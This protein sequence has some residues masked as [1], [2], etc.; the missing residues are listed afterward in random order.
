MRSI[1]TGISC[2]L[3]DAM[4]NV[5]GRKIANLRL[6]LVTYRANLTRRSEET[7]MKAL[8]ADVGEILALAD[9]GR[10]VLETY[11]EGKWPETSR[12]FKAKLSAV[13]LGR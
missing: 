2:R 8:L 12:F 7:L 4:R 9:L 5:D 10:K 13:R 3:E 6:L 11:P 1:S